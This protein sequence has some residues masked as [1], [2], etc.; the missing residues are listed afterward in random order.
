MIARCGI[1]VK[2]YIVIIV[3]FC[4]FD[5]VFGWT[6]IIIIAL[7]VLKERLKISF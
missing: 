1:F 5:V 3:I 4:L 2:W 6:I 7:F